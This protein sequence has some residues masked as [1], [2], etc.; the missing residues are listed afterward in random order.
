MFKVEILIRIRRIKV[1]K[2]CP[3]LYD[4]YFK[5]QDNQCQSSKKAV[6]F[7]ESAAVEHNTCIETA[8]INNS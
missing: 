5:Y 8:S 4:S 1:K 2:N 6:R 3:Q 7:S